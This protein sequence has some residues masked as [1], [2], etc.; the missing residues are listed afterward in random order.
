LRAQK[1]KADLLELEL[2]KRRGKLVEIAAAE[3]AWEDNVLSFRAKMLSIPVKAAPQLMWQKSQQEMQGVVDKEIREALAE[4]S[5][6]VDY[7]LPEPEEL[8]DF[9]AERAS[10]HS[11]TNRDG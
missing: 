7:K 10:S 6:P 1:A 8:P 11:I 9:D 4:L 2:H 3:Q 5:K